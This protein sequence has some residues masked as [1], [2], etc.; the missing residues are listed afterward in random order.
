MSAAVVA[1]RLSPKW[2]DA[3]I[4]L[5]A[6]A[7]DWP[8]LRTQYEGSFEHH[9]L[10]LGWVEHQQLIALLTIQNLKRV[11]EEAL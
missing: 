2:L 1:T 11:K 4:E 10:I 3:L 8:W 7:G 5:D 9:D 6:A